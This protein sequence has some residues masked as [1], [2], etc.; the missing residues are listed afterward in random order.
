MAQLLCAT[1]ESYFKVQ[2]EILSGP[3]LKMFFG[4]VWMDEGEGMKESGKSKSRIWFEM[5]DII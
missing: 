3:E 1:N 4:D 5:E 2:D